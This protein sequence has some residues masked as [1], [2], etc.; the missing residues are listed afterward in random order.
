[1][2]YNKN[3]LSLRS[4]LFVYLLSIALAALWFY[5]LIPTDQPDYFFHFNNFERENFITNFF[6]MWEVYIY[7]LCQSYNLTPVELLLDGLLNCS[8]TVE[9]TRVFKYILLTCAILFLLPK[10]SKSAITIPLIC[11]LVPGFVQVVSYFSAES[12]FLIFTISTIRSPSILLKGLVV[13]FGWLFFDQGA[14]FLFLL[15]AIF[16]YTWINFILVRK[17]RVALSLGA[18]LFIAVFVSID[19]LSYFGFIPLIGD[20]LV[21]IAEVYSTVYKDVYNNYPV[22]LRPILTFAGFI[23]FTPENFGTVLLGLV[24]YIFALTLVS[25]SLYR[26]FFTSSKYNKLISDPFYNTF[27]PAIIFIVI[28]TMLM[29]GYSNVKY[30]MFLLPVLIEGLL[31]KYNIAKIVNST[32]IISLL[33]F[34]IV[35][36]E[37]SINK[38]LF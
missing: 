38:N 18:L 14:A 1:M 2:K 31:L 22:I 27:V 26:V 15:Y 36:F 6:L 19:L 9:L 7:P 21:F 12:I 25:S 4:A 24:L 16:S 23:A 3:I 37:L 35:F 5:V 29:A 8:F 10:K 32:I 33:G 13:I 20:R 11:F 30:F 34:L 28:S 17:V